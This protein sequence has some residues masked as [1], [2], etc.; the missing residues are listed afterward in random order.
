MCVCVWV[1]ERERERD[2]HP[3]PEKTRCGGVASDSVSHTVST[4]HESV[5]QTCW[6]TVKNAQK[7]IIAVEH[8]SVLLCCK[9]CTAIDQWKNM[10]WQEVLAHMEAE[11]GTRAQKLKLYD[12]HHHPKQPIRGRIN[13]SNLRSYTRSNHTKVNNGGVRMCVHVNADINV[14]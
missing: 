8:I 11:M 2:I 3:Q 6:Q 4:S 14:K 1:W 9:S 5:K 12:L 7:C 13:V 10:K